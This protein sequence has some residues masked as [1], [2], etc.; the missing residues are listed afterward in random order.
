MLAFDGSPTCH[1]GIDMLAAS[2]L[3]RGLPIHVLMVG[4]DTGPAW[5]QLKEAEQRL[6]KGGHQVHL[7]IRAG[8]VEPTLH[9]YQLE[10][11]IDLLVMGAYGHSRIRQFLVGSTTSHLLRTSTSPLLILR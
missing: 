4:A 6:V 10:Q 1:K 9:A 5:E 2:P 7:A 3:F 11:G 8:E